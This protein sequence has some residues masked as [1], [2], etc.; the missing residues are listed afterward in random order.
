M[1]TQ[2]AL[3]FVARIPTPIFN[4]PEIPFNQRPLKKDSQ[5]RLMEMETIAFPGTK[6][7]CVKEISERILQV[8]TAEYHSTAPLYVDSRFLQTAPAEAS[9]REKNLP[10]ID[11][12]LRW[13]ED[14]IGLRY[15][16]GGNWEAGIPELLEFYPALKNA[17]PEDRDDAVCRGLDCSG[18][19]YQATNGYTPRNTSDLI[20]FGREVPLE[21][22]KPLDLLVWKGHMIVVRS[23]TT[24]IES[25]MGYGVVVSPFQQRYLE[26]SELLK[27][28]NKTLYIRRWYPDS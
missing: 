7:R 5:G 4:T 19:L 13:M 2:T 22:I 20:L 6:F 17:S 25:R 11:K 3:T 28:Q 26:V 27:T 16:W 12:I 23:P 24:L 1:S 9:E 10:S 8:E 21:Q 14:R 15:F 18:L